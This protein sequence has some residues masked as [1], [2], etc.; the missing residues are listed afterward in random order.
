[1]GRFDGAP[2][3]PVSRGE[4]PPDSPSN[5]STTSTLSSLTFREFFHGRRTNNGGSA[6][7]IISGESVKNTNDRHHFESGG[8][9]QG[10]NTGD[11]S[12]AGWDNWGLE[13]SLA[14][15]NKGTAPKI[16]CG[17][18]AANGTELQQEAN[19]F[20]RTTMCLE[21]TP[22]AGVGG[23]N[24][25]TGD[26]M[27]D[28]K[29]GEKA[30]RN[31]SEKTFSD[32]FREKDVDDL[33]RNQP[34]FSTSTSEDTMEP[35]S[36]QQQDT[37]DI[38]RS[39]SFRKGKKEKQN[40]KS[41]GE[42]NH[43]SF[44]DE[45]REAASLMEMEE[46]DMFALEVGLMFSADDGDT[47][48]NYNPSICASLTMESIDGTSSL[49]G[50]QQ[51]PSSDLAA[52]LNQHDHKRNNGNVQDLN[53]DADSY[54]Q[55]YI[56]NPNYIIHHP[57]NQQP[58]SLS[59]PRSQSTIVDDYGNKIP[60]NAK[61]IYNQHERN[62]QLFPTLIH[63]QRERANGRSLVPNNASGGNATN[64]PNSE[65]EMER[66]LR[67]IA[68]QLSSDWRGANS[69]LAPAL[70][71]RL[72]DFQFA[73]E[74]RRK[75]Y[76]TVKPWGILGLYDHLAGVR[77]DVEWAED[78]A[79]R[80]KHGH[81]YLTW[82]DFESTKNEGFNRPFFT[83]LIVSACTAMMFTSFLVND[84]RFEP[85]S[86]NPMLG[87][88][89]ETLLRLGAKD[90]YLIVQESEI[91]RLV[92]TMV[93]HAGLIHYLLNMFALWYVGKAIEQI[94]GFFPSLVIFVVSAVGGTILSAI[95][96]PEYITVGA[97]GG[98]FGLIGACISDIVLNW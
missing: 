74:K 15:K 95:F 41:R 23:K 82:V 96:L 63:P 24:G 29:N 67:E 69:I 78:A 4:S 94:H 59:S 16:F 30:R 3:S 56:Q 14:P 70:A 34:T 39:F 42:D 52:F 2:V 1:M 73:R 31:G 66:R 37:W 84:W 62:N 28:C 86:V 33:N 89:A 64:Q 11:F 85:I 21:K 25:I 7:G 12:S 76:G 68:G 50:K 79:W 19:E 20:D 26:R 18:S 60:P 72:R 13:R 40:K 46:N 57:R 38:T 58:L 45:D 98:I 47:I 5:Q 55:N 9:S 97:S 87:P 27:K 61:M 48:T 75:K 36:L 49:N 10:V 54:G 22:K 43:D 90:S 91:W 8:D 83:F 35:P 32:D 71:R 6:D 81:P 17:S 92:S 65:Q 77:I 53:G 44:T 51:D 80:R 88:S 93:L